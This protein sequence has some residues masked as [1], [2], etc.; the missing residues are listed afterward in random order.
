MSID[1]YINMYLCAQIKIKE[2]KNWKNLNE[3]DEKSLFRS[4]VTSACLKKGYSWLYSPE[5]YRSIQT[6]RI[7]NSL[8]TTCLVAID[9]HAIMDK[10]FLGSVWKWNKSH[11]RCLKKFDFHGD[12]LI[13]NILFC[14]CLCACKLCRQTLLWIR[15]QL[16]LF[17]R[18][19]RLSNISS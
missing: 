5:Q 19:E 11:F 3:I 7:V 2:I 13:E 6:I 14:S 17:V 9:A 4:F 8:L 15:T 16:N 18:L 12:H 10:N 1:V